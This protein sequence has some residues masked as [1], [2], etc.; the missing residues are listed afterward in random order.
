T[1]TRRDESCRGTMTQTVVSHPV[2]FFLRFNEWYNDG[3][4]EGPKLVTDTQSK[5]AA[6]HVRVKVRKERNL[7]HGREEI[8][9]I[10]HGT[11]NS[12][13]LGIQDKSTQSE[14]RDTSRT[15]NEQDHVYKLKKA[16]YGLKQAPRHGMTSSQLMDSG[17]TGG[18]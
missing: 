9:E 3:L 12:R 5:P 15:L 18:R 14:H 17:T 2:D 13:E 16:L 1:M 4:L 6:L 10:G 7:V 11:T 8:E